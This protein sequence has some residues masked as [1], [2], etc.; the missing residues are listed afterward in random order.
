VGW[1]SSG[2]KR[3]PT[4]DGDGANSILQFRLERGGDGTKYYRE[5]Q[6]RQQAHLGSMERKRDTVW[7]NDNV[8]QKRG[9]TRE[10]KGRRQH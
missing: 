10:G 1:E 5:M 2:K 7:W 8:G 9:D 4:A 3:W 6:Q